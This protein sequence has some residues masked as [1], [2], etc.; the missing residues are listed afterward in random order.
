MDN[1]TI[2][3]LQNLSAFLLF[4]LAFRWWVQPRLNKMTIYDA[5]LPVVFYHGIRFLGMTFM[6]DG[7]FY[8]GFP[9]DD[10]FMIGVGDYVVSVL[11]IITAIALKAKKKFAIPLTWFTMIVGLVDLVNAFRLVGAQEFWQYDIEGIWYLMLLTGPPAIITTVYAF[12]RLIKPGK[13][14]KVLAHK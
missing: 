11:A 9:E 14:D 2:F 4:Y 1:F 5:L 13:V 7:Q 3:N 6:V 12:Y 8:D 10:A